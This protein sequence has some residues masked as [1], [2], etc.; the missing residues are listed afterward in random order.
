M[1]IMNLDVPYNFWYYWHLFAVAMRLPQGLQPYYSSLMEAFISIWL[2]MPAFRAAS[3]SHSWYYNSFCV[4]CISSDITVFSLSLICRCRKNVAMLLQ[5]HMSRN[6]PRLVLGSTWFE[7][8]F[9]WFSWHNWTTSKS[10]DVIQIILPWHDVR[11]E[12]TVVIW[13]LWKRPRSVNK[14]VSG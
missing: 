2:Q 9:L 3:V 10:L 5:Q 14:S 4:T 12:S 11:H 13:H 1:S 7:L 6:N 8:W